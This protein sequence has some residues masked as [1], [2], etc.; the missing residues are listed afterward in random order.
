MVEAID[1]SESEDGV[2]IRYEG[3]ARL[4]EDTEVKQSVPALIRRENPWSLTVD[5]TR[6]ARSYLY[7]GVIM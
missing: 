6:E 7:S 2:Q 3:T 1:D 4:P 5:E